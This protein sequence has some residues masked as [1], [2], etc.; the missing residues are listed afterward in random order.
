MPQKSSEEA[1]EE[2]ARLV[3]AGFDQTA[4]KQELDALREEVALFQEDVASHFAAVERSLD[5]IEGQ[6]RETNIV[7]GPLTRTVAEME[8][9]I[10]DLEARVDRLEKKVDFSK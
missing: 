2:L 6:T 9:H 4:T 3:Q 7:L 10:Q 8:V 1:I 5:A